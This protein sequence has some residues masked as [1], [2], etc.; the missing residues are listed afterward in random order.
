T[1]S[2]TG[3]PWGAESPQPAV[4]TAPSAPSMAIARRPA[5]ARAGAA[6]EVSVAGRRPSHSVIAP[7]F[8]TGRGLFLYSPR[9]GGG[10]HV[11]RRPPDRRLPAAQGAAPQRRGQPLRRRE[12]ARGAPPAG[13]RPA[14]LLGAGH[15]AA[16]GGGGRGAG[17]RN[18]R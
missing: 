1:F 4:A 18:R 14:R 10:D 13:E 8:S 12:R 9:R 6:A 7:A 5:R 17:R 2:N 3:G 15:F 11:V 16:H